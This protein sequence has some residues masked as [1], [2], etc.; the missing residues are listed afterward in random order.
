MYGKHFASMYKGSM[1]G[2]GAP[3]F[4][5]MGYVVSN[6]VP[7]KEVGYQVELNPILLGTI[8]GEKVEVIEKAIAFLCKPDVK[9][10]SKDD[11]GRRLVRLGEF[12]YRVVNGVKYAM[13]VNEELR[14]EQNRIR[15][16]RW[17]EK[18]KKVPIVHKSLSERNAEKRENEE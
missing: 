2:A 1:V 15:Q 18:R 4:A 10:R 7:D 8:L 9:S 14:R 12:D 16:R 3:V 17:V 13:I 5:V 11:Y 6:M